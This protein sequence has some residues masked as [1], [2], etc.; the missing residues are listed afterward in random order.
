[1]RFRLLMLAAGVLATTTLGCNHSATTVTGKVTYEGKPVNK[2]TISFLP[3]DGQ[4]PSCGG[5]I[6]SGRFT[7]GLSPGKKIV[8][9][10]E[11]KVSD[12]VLTREEIEQEATKQEQAD[13]R[14]E[15]SETVP[16]DADGNNAEIEVQSGNQT[17]DFALKHPVARRIVPHR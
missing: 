15:G 2:G 4:G 10:V 8:R 1:M 9:I 17:L 5:P 3:I 12:H 7:V 6:E 11:T 13:G 14:I 16:P